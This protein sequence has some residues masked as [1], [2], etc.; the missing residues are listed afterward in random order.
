MIKTLEIK[1][2]K[3]IKD[4]KLD[5]RRINIFIGEP[6][7]GKSNILETVGIF[8]FGGYGRVL[9][10]E[11]KN[12]VRFERVSNLFYD[13]DLEQEITISF[14]GYL[15]NLKFQKGNFEGSLQAESTSYPHAFSGSYEDISSVILGALRPFKFYR[16]SRR[17]SFP[18]RESDFLLPPSGDNLLSLLL[19]NKE[20]RSI[21]NQF[22][23][24]FGL[25]LGLRPQESKIELIKQ[26]ED[27]IISY[28][29]SVASETLQGVVFHFAAVLSNKDSILAFEEP[30]AHAFPYYT[31]FL[32]EEIA[33]DNRGNQYLISTHNPFFLEPLIEKA[34]EEELN[35]FITYLENYE[36]KVKPLTKEQKERVLDFGG[37]V[38]FNLEKLLEG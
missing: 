25:R 15:L 30:E 8:S 33:L 1:N 23:S 27:I 2:F 36:T 22:F 21:A 18:S 28:P 31:K 12:F 38:F 34:K 10:L 9:N 11:S 3:S 13:E 32:A 6:N 5:L 17:E 7:T 20:P 24:S 4:L 37:D 14:D 26:L 35:V 29:Y 16:F 19:T